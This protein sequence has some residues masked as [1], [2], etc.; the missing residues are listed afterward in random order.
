[1]TRFFLYSHDTY[2]LGH[3]RR[4][5]LLA[6]AI[7]DANPDDEVLI[8]TGSPQAQAFAL[9]ERVD[10]L[11]LPSA[12]KDG[13][14]EY[15]PRKLGGSIHELVAL[16]SSVVMAALAAY[17]PDVIVV[18]HAPLG[19]AGELVPML[20]RYAGC[21][22]APRLVLGLRDIIDDADQVDADWQRSGVWNWLDAYDDIF[23]Y[24][25]PRI[26]TTASE[27]DLSARVGAA[28]THTGYVAP[29][30]P[31]PARDIEPFLLVTPGG[32]GDGQA[33]L[34]RYLDAVEAGATSGVK[35][36]VVTG[37]LMSSARR[38][39]LVERARRSPSITIIEFTD[40]MR[41]LVACASGVVSMAGY[42]TVV[43]E[44]AADVPALLVPRCEPRLEQDIRARRLAPLT[45]LQHCPVEQLDAT[46][47]NEFV[48]A[49]L[50]RGCDDRHPAA[51][52]VALDGAANAAELLQRRSRRTP[53]AFQLS[54]RPESCHDTPPSARAV[55][56]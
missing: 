19:M 18:D 14:G 49:S 52:T 36:L 56:V 8:A 32:G 10:S 17:A 24:G 51:S 23:V 20:Q 30:M 29:T 48:V 43:E 37:P 15:Q 31:R 46:A 21:S 33:V 9:P 34:R 41:D 22:H 42:N 26:P 44:L 6:A 25:D 5:T 1:M 39:E 54:S 35:S 55:P 12:T 53:V 28:V 16:R 13:A 38:H 45:R 27:L 50:A 47:V 11:K 40:Q 2:G 4:S 3:L 7:V